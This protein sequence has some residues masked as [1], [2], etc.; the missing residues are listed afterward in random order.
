MA[1]GGGY[2]DPLSIWIP[3]F[4]GMTEGVGFPL[5]AGVP[6][7]VRPPRRRPGPSWGTGVTTGAFR[8][9]GL[10]NWAPAFAGEG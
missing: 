4:A 2:R 8:Y 5:A 10:T 9:C 3:A 1:G 6:R 7:F